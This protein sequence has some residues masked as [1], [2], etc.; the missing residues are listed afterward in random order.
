M[1]GEFSELFPI[2]RE[3]LACA[4]IEDGILRMKAFNPTERCSIVVN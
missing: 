3:I 2:D 4:E 1:N